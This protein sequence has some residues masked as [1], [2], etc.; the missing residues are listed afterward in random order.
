MNP[1]GKKKLPEADTLTV[2]RVVHHVDGLGRGSGVC[3]GMS[4]PVDRSPGLS[5]SAGL[6][7]GPGDP[8]TFGGPSLPL[9][10]KTHEHAGPQP[11]QVSSK[12]DL[13][14]GSQV[15]NSHSEHH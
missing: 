1:G 14:P 3:T 4:P 5:N 15:H 12:A 6:D 13:T 10:L 2:V 8:R 7:A 11:P 9:G